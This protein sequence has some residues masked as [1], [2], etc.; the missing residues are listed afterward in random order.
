[1]P[2]FLHA[3]VNRLGRSAATEHETVLYDYLTR[4]PA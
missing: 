1:V 4:Q 2:A 3:F